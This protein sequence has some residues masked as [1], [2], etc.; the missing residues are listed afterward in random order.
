MKKLKY[1][2][3]DNFL[4]QNDFNKLKDMVFADG[5]PYYYI[6]TLNDNQKDVS[7]K[8]PFY[9]VHTVFE[10]YQITSDCFF[11]LKPILDKISAKAL[12]RM[13]I[14]FYPKT[15]KI[16]KHAFHTDLDFPHKGCILYFNDCNGYTLLEDGTK[17]ETKENRVL[18]FNSGRPHASTSCTDKK[19]RVNLNI[20]YL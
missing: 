17:I 7:D 8:S 15:P 5:F 1:K 4:N 14:N 3:I 11:N 10:K 16:V 9:F 18:L 6:K 19:A 2:I 13:K 12:I 20:N